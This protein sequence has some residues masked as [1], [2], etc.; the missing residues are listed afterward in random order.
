MSCITGSCAFAPNV[1]SLLSRHSSCCLRP[2]PAG[3]RFYAITTASFW[4]LASRLS[5]YANVL[6][7]HWR[8]VRAAFPGPFSVSD[9]ASPDSALPAV[10]VLA[11]FRAL[12]VVPAE[13]GLTAHAGAGRDR[14]RTGLQVA[15][16]HAGLQ[17]IDA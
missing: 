16:H 13:L 2:P 3:R 11:G 12:A 17:Q 6:F 10:A 8:S 9:T 4:P 15:D 1:R 7:A 5:A 14:Q